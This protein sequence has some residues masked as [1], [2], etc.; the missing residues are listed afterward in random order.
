MSADHVPDSVYDAVAPYF[1]EG[2]LVALTFAIVTINSWSRLSISFRVPPGSYV[3]P[4][5]AV[6]AG[7]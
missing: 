6:A 4:H 7:L 1:S 2:E 3:S 5:A